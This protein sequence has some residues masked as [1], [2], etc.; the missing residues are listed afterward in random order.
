MSVLNKEVCLPLVVRGGVYRCQYTVAGGPKVLALVDTG[1]PFLILTS[2]ATNGKGK[3]SRYTPTYEM[4]ASQA[5]DV[6]WE[7]GPVVLAEGAKFRK[8]VYGVFQDTLANYGGADGV[9]FGLIRNKNDDIRPSFLEQTNVR[10]F[11]LDF[12][13]QMLTLS[14]RSLI[15][16]Q[17][18]VPLLDLRRLFR[19]P[20]QHYVCQ[21]DRMYVNGNLVRTMSPIYAL[22][23]TGCTGMLMNAAFYYP[24]L[25]LTRIGI[26]DMLLTIKTTEGETISLGASRRDPQFLAL[27]QVFPWLPADACLLVVGLAFLRGRVLTIDALKSR[28]TLSI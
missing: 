11:R 22:I 28:M 21:V 13:N 4:Y 1:S 19:C 3:R 16:G 15:D 23:D 18:V 10:S 12:V 14:P 8:V 6:E 17:H 2:Q 7:E 9:I 5:G 26:N 25:G 24:L 20:V 27:P